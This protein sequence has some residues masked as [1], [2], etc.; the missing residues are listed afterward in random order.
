MLSQKQADGKLHPVAYDSRSLSSNDKRYAITDLET[1]AVVWAIGH[2]Q[3]YLYGQDVTISTD[4]QAV[5]AILSSLN[6]S[7]KHVSWW[8]NVY[9]SG[10]CTIDITYWPGRENTN[11]NALSRQP[12]QLAPADNTASPFVQ[13]ASILTD[14]EDAMMQ[15]SPIPSK[16]GVEQQK[17]AV[18]AAV[19]AYLT[20]GTL[21]PD[22]MSG[23]RQLVA[24]SSELA[25]VDGILYHLGRKSSIPNQQAVVPKHLRAELLE[26]MYGGLM[27]GH[28]SGPRSYHSLSCS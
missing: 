9:S 14:A 7:G 12:C 22:N 16:F 8:S 15:Q 21:P 6:A 13:V 17:P 20:T 2:F 19:I 28:F 18:L 10:L 23:A 25:L 1:L 11:A 3:Y 4:H 27:A 24:R 26:Q 5:K